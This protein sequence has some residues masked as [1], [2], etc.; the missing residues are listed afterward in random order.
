MPHRNTSIFFI[1]S[2]LSFIAL[3]G[4][5][6]WGADVLGFFF[7][8]KTK[9][10]IL[11]SSAIISVIAFILY[12]SEEI[13]LKRSTKKIGNSYYTQSAINFI[14]NKNISPETIDNI[15]KVGSVIKRNDS[16]KYT[17]TNPEGIKYIII[18]NAKGVVSEVAC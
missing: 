8:E 17:W 2:I 6:A 10:F 18:T 9:K 15:I 14:N 13:K 3:V 1:I 11:I 4:S 12:L 5:G 7:E 16:F